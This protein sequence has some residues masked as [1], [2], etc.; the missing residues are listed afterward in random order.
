LPHDEVIVEQQK[1]HVLLLVVNN[2]KN[3]QGI[4]TGKVFEYM[5][6]QRPILAI[7]PEDGDLAEILIHSG[8]DA[9]VEYTAVETLK[10]R[11]AAYYASA[12]AQ[13]RKVT[14]EKFDRRNLTAE[15]ARFFELSLPH[16]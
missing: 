11:I 8:F 2:T 1:S 4:V 10:T 9:P 3:A 16:E 7:G 12:P 15:L 6:A 13:Q 14:I 5:A